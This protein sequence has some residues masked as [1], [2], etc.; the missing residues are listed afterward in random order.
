MHNYI[1]PS[2]KV[3]VCKMCTIPIQTENM[4]ANYKNMTLSTIH[5]HHQYYVSA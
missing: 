1:P 4:D 5:I 3:L 2:L